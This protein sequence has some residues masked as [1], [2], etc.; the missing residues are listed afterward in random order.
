MRSM[1]KATSQTLWTGMRGHGTLLPWALLGRPPGRVGRYS[2]A[3]A[4]SL[5]YYCYSTDPGWRKNNRGIDDDVIVLGPFAQSWSPSQE[6][7]AFGHKTPSTESCVKF[8]SK[9]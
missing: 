6:F 5:V 7:C 2:G 4:A 9:A 1:P 3:K 8:S